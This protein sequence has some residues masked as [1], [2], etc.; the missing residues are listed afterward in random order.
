MKRKIKDF[1]NNGRFRGG[2]NIAWNVY[3]I[4]YIKKDVEHPIDK[5]SLEI[6]IESPKTNDKPIKPRSLRM[7]E[8]DQV[9]KLINDLTE[10]YTLF[11]IRRGEL[12]IDNYQSIIKDLLTSVGKTMNK[13][14][15]GR[16]DY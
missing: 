4:Y 13:A 5:I 2:L 6:T 15:T 8:P 14:I 10:S 11:K 9:K 16:N 7:N 3:N 12:K 1:I